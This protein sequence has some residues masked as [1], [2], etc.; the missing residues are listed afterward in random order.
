MLHE[1]GNRPR[2]SAR[3]AARLPLRPLPAPLMLFLGAIGTMLLI[4]AVHDLYRW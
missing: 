1:P 3:R 4:T 2:T